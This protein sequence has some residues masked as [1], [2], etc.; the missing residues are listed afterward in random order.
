MSTLILLLLL[1]ILM[2]GAYKGERFYAA[3]KR[4]RCSVAK[5]NND[6]SSGKLCIIIVNII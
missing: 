1:S 4:L 3:I 5:L 6:L 2:I